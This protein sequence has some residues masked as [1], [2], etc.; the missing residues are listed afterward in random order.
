MGNGKGHCLRVSTGPAYHSTERADYE[1]TLLAR[2]IEDVQPTL[3][4]LR[5][6]ERAASR[7]GLKDPTPHDIM[8]DHPRAGLESIVSLMA[9]GGWV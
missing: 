2:M 3:A 8:G 4:E 9:T 6:C 7:W 1:R 5:R